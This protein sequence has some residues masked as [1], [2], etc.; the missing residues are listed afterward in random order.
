MAVYLLVLLRNAFYFKQGHQNIHGQSQKSKTITHHGLS[1]LQHRTQTERCSMICASALAVCM[2]HNWHTV[3]TV[4]RCFDSVSDGHKGT[5]LHPTVEDF[6]TK[7]IGI[8]SSM[9]M[10][11]GQNKEWLNKTIPN[12]FTL[13]LTVP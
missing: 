10:V 7:P 9:K 2:L 6:K 3:D 11:K 13:F 5:G 8:L 1:S 12:K 4:S